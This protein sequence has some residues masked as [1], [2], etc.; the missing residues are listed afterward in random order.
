MQRSAAHELAHHLGLAHNACTASQSLM[1]ANFESVQCTATSGFATAPTIDD[2]IPFNK[3]VYNG[4]T[5]N[6]CP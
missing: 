5:E 2:D 1:Q 3:T 4:G 6:S